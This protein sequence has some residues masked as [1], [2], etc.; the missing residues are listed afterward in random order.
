MWVLACVLLAYPARLAAED[1]EEAP[2]FAQGRRWFDR[3]AAWVGRGDADALGAV[4]DVHLDLDAKFD[5][6]GTHTEG[7]M[8][9][10]LQPPDRYRQESGLNRARTIRIVDGDL[11]WLVTAQG[12]IRPLVLT[13]EGRRTLAQLQQD[14]QRLF[15]L[16]RYLSLG[17]LRTPGA[18]FELEADTAGDGVEGTVRVRRRRSGEHDLVF[19]L[20]VRR[21]AAGDVEAVWPAVVREIAPVGHATREYV[22]DRW[23][24]PDAPRRPYRYPRRIEGLSV[25]LSDDGT[26]RRKR[27]LFAIVDDIRINAGLEPTLFAPPRR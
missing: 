7:R 2:A 18:T 12:R 26:P 1:P 17:A 11:G 6:G 23:E 9:F 22:L 25:N 10:W 14:R 3:A 20:A 24:D 16:M 19:V 13:A 21:D 27:F 8:R 5:S 4:E 15:G